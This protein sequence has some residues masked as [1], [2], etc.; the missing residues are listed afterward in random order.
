MLT[1]RLE[2]E[3][4]L[5]ARIS[6][7]DEMAFGIVFNHYKNRI[8]S[9]AFK[10]LASTSIAE[11]IVQ[12]V[13]LIIWLKR[14]DLADIKNFSAYLFVLTRN[15]VYKALKQNA[16]YY[17]SQILSEEDQ[18]LMHNDTENS[19][20]EKE[21][22]LLLQKAINRLPLQQQKVYKLMKEQGLKRAEV[23]NLL[24]IHPE[25][26]KSHMAQAMRSIR[27]YCILHSDIHLGIIICIF[28][29]FHK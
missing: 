6:A 10:L 15:N 13:F 19:V 5:L 28:R 14:A 18:L 29:L 16:R 27:A 17:K 23:A 12:D 24:D 8:Y 20:M 25:T 4:V 11:E 26:I 21:Y 1:Q 2:N 7:G 22:N 9:I 3:T